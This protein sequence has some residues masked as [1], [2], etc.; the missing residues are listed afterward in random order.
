MAKAP[1]L[2]RVITG[3][4]LCLSVVALIVALAPASREL[5]S[6]RVATVDLV[7]I[8]NAERAA[9]PKLTKAGGGD[10]SLELL[11]IGK[12]IMPTVRQVAGPG[13]LVLVKQAVVGKGF[14]DITNKVLVK[15]GLPTHAATINLSSGLMVAP[16]TPNAQ[17]GALWKRHEQ[18]QR[19]RQ[20]SEVKAMQKKHVSAQLP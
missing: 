19:Q 7:K 12:Q 15:L 14:N 5:D 17:T 20:L 2:S 9:L 3:S 13:T 16:T 1:I 10:P 18:A 11:R 8:M 4:A 6:G